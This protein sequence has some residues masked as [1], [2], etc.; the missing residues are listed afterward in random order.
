MIRLKEIIFEEKTRFVNIFLVLSACSDNK[1]RETLLRQPAVF[2][3]YSCQR[4][5]LN[6]LPNK[7]V[8]KWAAFKRKLLVT[9]EVI[10][11]CFYSTVFCFYSTVF[12]FVKYIL[13]LYFMETS[14]LSRHLLSG[15]VLKK[16]NIS[17]EDTVL[18]FFSVL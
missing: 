7:N 6:V 17:D 3:N 1:C 11:F 12:F 16:Q 18:D 14:A 9:L 10:V 15:L 5:S 4:F 8:M 13:I 2:P